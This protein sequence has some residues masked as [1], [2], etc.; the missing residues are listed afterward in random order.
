[1]TKATNGGR[2][3]PNY[4]LNV[5]NGLAEA[6]QLMTEHNLDR[7]PNQERLGELG[8]STLAKRISTDYGGF[9]NFRRLLGE[10]ATRVEHG[11]WRD[12]NYTIKEAR[13]FKRKHSRDRRSHK[14]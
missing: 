3:S 10:K 6:R 1:M 9:H 12:L 7:L 5:G 8:H 4:W 2:K 11:Q 14:E 13:K